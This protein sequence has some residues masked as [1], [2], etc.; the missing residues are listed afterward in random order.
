V[1]ITGTKIMILKADSLIYNAPSQRYETFLNFDDYKVQIRA[2][3]EN[4]GDR[5]TINQQLSDKVL[6]LLNLNEQILTYCAG[7]LLET[8]NEAW[9]DDGEA[10]V[11]EAKF[12]RA[13]H[14]YQVDFQKD[15]EI[16][17]S[18]QAGNFFWGHVVVVGLGNDYSFKY[19]TLEG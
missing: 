10:P 16:T 7:Q 12:K 18:Y 4:E 14:F 19:A 1:E 8:K 13:L 5:D 9:L 2:G 3:Y 15:G 11:D 6:R 17:L